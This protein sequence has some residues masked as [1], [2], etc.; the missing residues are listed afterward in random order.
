MLT[1]FANYDGPN[2]IVIAKSLYDKEII[3]WAF[4]QSIPLE[5]YPAHLP[6]YPLTIRF[7]DIFM[8]GTWSMLVATLLAT[9][10]AVFAFYFLVKKYNFSSN[11][12]LLSIIFLFLP[13]RWL[14]VRS[15][16]SPEPLFIFAILASLYFFNDKR[17][18]GLPFLA[19]SL[20]LLKLPAYYCLFHIL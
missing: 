9:I 10:G 14:V 17:Y 12:L 4:S 8:P 18:C 3:R 6:G 19:L 16:G 5:Y 2:Y 20:K 1:V 7:L 11:P 13:A 15:V